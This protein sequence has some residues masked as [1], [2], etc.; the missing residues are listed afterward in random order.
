M[1]IGEVLIVAFMFILQIVFG[2][3][4]IVLI[5][6]VWRACNTIQEIGRAVQLMAYDLK[7]IREKTMQKTGS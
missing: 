6:K 7:D 1:G 5:V 4:A 2:I 3:V